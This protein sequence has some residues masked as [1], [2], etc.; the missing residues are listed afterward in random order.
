MK[1]LALRRLAFPALALTAFA[2]ACT[3]LGLGPGV[4]PERTATAEA[5]DGGLALTVYNQGTALVR[6][7]RQ[8]EFREGLNDLR[9]GD[10]AAAI[11]PTS[12]LFSSLSDPGGTAVLEQNYEFDL[13]GAAALLE[14]Y[15]D[16]QIRVVTSDGTLY[17]GTLLSGRGDV[18]LQDDDGRVT[19]VNAD[20]IQEFSFPELPEG[21]ITRPTLAWKLLAEQAGLQDVEITY[22]TGG[23]SWSADYVLLLAANERSIDLDGW[24]TVVNTSGTTYR[25]ALL[26][27]V[28]GDLQRLPEAGFAADELQL[29]A[30]PTATAE[31]IEQREFFEYHLYE[32]PRPVTVRDNETKQIEFVRSPG[33]AAAKFFVYDG[34]QC[35]SYYWY[36]GYSGYPQT[37]PSY[38][39]AS[40]PK[41]M[42]M[43]EFDT[44]DVEA[45]LPRG[46]IRVYQEDVDGA[47]LLIGEDTIDHTPKGETLRLYVG[48]AFDIVGERVQTDFRLPSQKTIE[49]TYRITL[50]NHKDEKVEVR[51]VEHL[52]RWTNW[53]IL[54]SS[55]DYDE[56]DSS[57]IEFRVQIPPEGE[58]ELTYTVRYSWP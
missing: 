41:V 39:I 54:R 7:R 18:I 32:V 43:V 20:D 9:F 46:R 40:N 31:A 14:K 57:T 8:F 34:L 45:D 12:V 3:S 11:D 48:D 30:M 23:V 13:V 6:D 52:F 1:R 36:C 33:V 2:I 47:A 42:V 5:A 37:D 21:L 24:V 53:R 22:L 28:A 10:V 44:D 26:K 51:V 38:G 29:R 55:H 17:E 35:R 49:E 19:V 58:T 15:L 25:D 16:E 27:L 56:M 50:R 4:T